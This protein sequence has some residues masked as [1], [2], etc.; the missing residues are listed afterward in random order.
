[1]R[2][3]PGFLIYNSLDI[4]VLASGDF[5]LGAEKGN[6][7]YQPGLYRASAVIPGGL[8]NDGTYY[9]TLV[10]LKDLSE[11]AA[12]Q[13]KAVCFQVNDDGYGRGAYTSAWIGIVRPLLNWA[14]KP[15]GDV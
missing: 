11:R 12:A 9:V 7:M 8:L 10:I 4:C 1:M 14:V 2:L 3:T 6:T 5:L 13:S 15:I